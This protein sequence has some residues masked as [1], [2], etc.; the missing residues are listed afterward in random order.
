[1]HNLAAMPLIGIV[2][3]PIGAIIMHHVPIIIK[4]GIIPHMNLLIIM[5]LI[6][7][8]KTPINVMKI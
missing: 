6:F 2:K 3:T 4:I 8:T 5:V 7:I 1:M